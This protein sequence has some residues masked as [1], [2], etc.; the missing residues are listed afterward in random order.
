MFKITKPPERTNQL[1][2]WS[3]FPTTEALD[4]ARMLHPPSYRWGS[5]PH[6]MTRMK[7]RIVSTSPLILL[8]VSQF[9]NHR[10]SHYPRQFCIFRLTR[11]NRADELTLACL[12]SA[13][14]M[15]FAS[16][17][18]PQLGT[19]TF[20]IS[21]WDHEGPVKKAGKFEPVS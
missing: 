11:D 5:L 16:G 6:T 7:I 13:T 12:A 3:I 8:M 10:G 14:S 1:P 21:G 17:L 20:R 19:N 2:S 18:L 9:T 4:G 15:T